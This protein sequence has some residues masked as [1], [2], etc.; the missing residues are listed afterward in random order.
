MTAYQI[1]LAAFRAAHAAL[2][3]NRDAETIR[4]Y[5][6][7]NKALRAIVRKGGSN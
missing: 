2:I 7:T 4:A 3:A 6:V 1:A 5:Q